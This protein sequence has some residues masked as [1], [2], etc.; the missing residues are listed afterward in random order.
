MLHTVI[1]DSISYGVET[2]RSTAH[3]QKILQHGIPH[4]LTSHDPRTDHR[5]TCLHE[6]NQGRLHDLNISKQ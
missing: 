3:I 4:I 6:E 5:E 2:Q 1:R